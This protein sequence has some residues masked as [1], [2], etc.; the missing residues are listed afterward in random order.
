MENASKRGD[1][2]GRRKHKL[3]CG[4]EQSRRERMTSLNL[5]SLS[6]IKPVWQDVIRRVYGLPPYKMQ[7]YLEISE[8]LG[9]SRQ[10]IGD[11]RN[12]AEAKLLR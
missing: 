8:A 7:T 6:A 10:R 12:R 11:I 3:Q 2:T 5:E 4:E 9:V 1:R